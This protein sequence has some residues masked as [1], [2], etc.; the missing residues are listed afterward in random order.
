MRNLEPREPSAGGSG[1]ISAA[2]KRSRFYFEE[3]PQARIRRF[4][5]ASLSL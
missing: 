4:T 3:F 1:V 2:E 5:A